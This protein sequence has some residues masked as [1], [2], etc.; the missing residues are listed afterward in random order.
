[1]R[2]AFD[3][4]LQYVRAPYVMFAQARDILGEDVIGRLAQRARATKADVVVGDQDNFPGPRRGADEPW[5]RYFGKGASQVERLDD[6]PYLVFS[7]GLGAKLLRTRLLRDQRLRSGLGPG[8]E[9]AWITVP[10]LLHARRVALAPSATC[11]TRDEEQRDSL[12]DVPWNDP[13]KTQELIRLCLYL[14]SRVGE[15]RPRSARLA[16]RFVVRTFQP[17]L[18]NLYRIMNRSELAA[19]FPALRELYA[20]IPDDLILQYATAAQSRLLHHAVRTGNFELL[21]DPLSK[22]EYRPHLHIDDAGLHRGLA[23][24][25][26]AT[27]LLRIDR[28]KAVLE[29]FHVEPEHIEFKGLLV[30]TGTDISQVFDNRIE[31]VLSDGTRERT[32]PEEQVYR[33][34]LWRT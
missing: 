5:K 19:L 2:S 9:D 27:S 13:V 7:T 26:V 21:C 24:D 6:A 18:R 33:R 8:Y 17:Y 3:N 31:Q 25:P 10:A 23:V 11:Y 4:G 20:R 30:Y 1:R 32:V 29:T 34:D 14:M 12:F 16:Q 22:P 28:Q 15:L